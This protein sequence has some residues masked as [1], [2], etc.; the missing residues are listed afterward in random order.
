[1]KKTT[2]VTC[3]SILGQVAARRGETEEA[4]GHFKQALE[5]AKASRLPM[6][7]VLAARDWRD[8]LMGP[9]GADSGAAEAVIDA[10]CAAMKK[11]RGDLKRVLNLQA[12]CDTKN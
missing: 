2:L 4:E 11:T 12:P 3:H 7:E 5:E 9:A 10:A 8:H 6:L 1:M